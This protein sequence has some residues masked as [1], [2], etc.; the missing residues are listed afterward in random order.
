MMQLESSFGD[1]DHDVNGDGDPN[2]GFDTVRRGGEKTFNP[3]VLLD[4]FEEEFNLPTVSVD[5]S[6]S[7]GRYEEVVSEE[8]ETLVDFFRVETDAPQRIWIRRAVSLPVKR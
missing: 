4:P 1:D 8:D 7:Q 5:G 2:L 3:K 6:H